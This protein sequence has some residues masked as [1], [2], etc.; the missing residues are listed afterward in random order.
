MVGRLVGLH[1]VLQELDLVSLFKG[2]LL[3]PLIVLSQGGNFLAE[4]I[5]LCLVFF[6]LIIFV[7]IVLD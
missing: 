7:I 5:N 6:N 4:R 1:S 3:Q 2:L